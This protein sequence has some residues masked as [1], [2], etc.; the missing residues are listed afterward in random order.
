MAVVRPATVG[1]DKKGFRNGAVCHQA[2]PKGQ[3]KREAPRRQAGASA[4]ASWSHKRQEHRYGNGAARTPH[5][6]SLAAPSPL[7]VVMSPLSHYEGQG[8]CMLMLRRALLQQQAGCPPFGRALSRAHG[9]C[10]PLYAQTAAVS[11]PIHSIPPHPLPDRQMSKTG[12]LLR[13]RPRGRAKSE[14]D[15]RFWRALGWSL[16][17]PFV[18]EPSSW[19]PGCEIPEAPSSW[20]FGVSQGPLP[21]C[22]HPNR[23]RPPDCL[24]KMSTIPTKQLVLR[25]AQRLMVVGAYG[26]PSPQRLSAA[27]LSP[28]FWNRLMPDGDSKRP[29]MSPWRFQIPNPNGSQRTPRNYGKGRGCVWCGIQNG[30]RSKRTRDGAAA[31]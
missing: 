3:Q 5:L 8:L 15:A 31:R 1:A 16:G 11:R 27:A 10:L 21:A 4:R 24:P 6:P 12:L 14:P 17:E 19:R 20:L 25:R 7:A 23:R 9:R 26:L 13:S 2:A 18:A 29:V 22:A 28:P 30:R